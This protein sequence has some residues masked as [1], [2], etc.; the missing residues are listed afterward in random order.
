ML[1]KH[2]RASILIHSGA[3]VMPVS[4]LALL[5]LPSSVFTSLGNSGQIMS[6][7]M[8]LLASMS[9]AYFDKLQSY[10]GS[11]PK[12]VEVI[13]LI[14]CNNVANELKKVENAESTL[15]KTLKIRYEA[16]VFFSQGHAF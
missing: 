16:W 3:S 13:T 9:S 14:N 15:Q 5:F 2:P 1:L 10:N 4:I 11:I 12:E 8:L 6:A 7:D